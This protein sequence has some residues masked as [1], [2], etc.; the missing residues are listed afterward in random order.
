MQLV[1]N[2]HVV[3][4]LNVHLSHKNLYLICEYCNGGNLEQYIKA[5]GRLS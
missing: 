1:D 4:L 5:K 2:P 3:R